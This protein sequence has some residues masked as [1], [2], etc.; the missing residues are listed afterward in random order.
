MGREGPHIDPDPDT[1]ADT[2]SDSDANAG[3]ICSLGL[4]IFMSGRIGPVLS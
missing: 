4:L 3:G 2:D 1:D